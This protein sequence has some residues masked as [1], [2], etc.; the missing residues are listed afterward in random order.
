MA[1]VGQK[2]ALRLVGRVGLL[3]CLF[4]LLG[5]LCDGFFQTLP[6]LLQFTI[7]FANLIH[8][9]IAALGLEHLSYLEQTGFIGSDDSCHSISQLRFIRV[10]GVDR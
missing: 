10:L 8:Q 9:F 5:A 6:M 3:H 2:I 7:L 4:E 1:H